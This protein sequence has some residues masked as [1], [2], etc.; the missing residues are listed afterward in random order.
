M[1]IEKVCHLTTAHRSDDVRILTRE[2]A[3]LVALPWI[4]LTL[5]APGSD[6]GHQKLEF[7]PLGERPNSRLKRIFFSQL[8]AGKAILSVR[9]QIWHLHDPEL[10]AIAAILILFR[11]KVIW[12]AHEDY[13]V[14]FSLHSHYRTYLP[15]IF[16]KSLSAVILALLKFVDRNA[17]GVIAATESIQNKYENSNCV[18]IGNEARAEEFESAKP[19][20]SSNKLLFL[21]STTD[22]HCF[23]QTVDAVY[24][25]KKLELIVAGSSIDSDIARNTKQLLGDRVTFIGWANRNQLLDLIS[26]SVGGMVTY[27]NLPTYNEGEPTKLFEFLMSGLPIVATPIK[28]NTHYLELSG[29]G[30]VSKGFE[31]SDLR[32]SLEKL[33]GSEEEWTSMS[34]KGRAWAYE[35]AS[36]RKSESKLISFYEQ[37]TNV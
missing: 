18:V 3:S 20:F 11:R 34:Q 28:P 21:G 30:L 17:V 12:D 13:F 15:K 7:F 9:A 16:R 23:Q 2:C 14:Q 6:P 32:E 1:K 26:D 33:L 37:V 29:G 4:S 25:F 36:W 24:S 31:S 5:A 27:Q 19:R 10:L 8:K 22:T 35:N